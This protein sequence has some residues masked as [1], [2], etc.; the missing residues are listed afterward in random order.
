M[1]TNQVYP[2]STDAIQIVAVNEKRETLTIKNF[3]SLD[4]KTGTLCRI[5]N[6]KNVTKGEGYILD[7]N[8]VIHL[9]KAD[10]D[11][12]DR[13]WYARMVSGTGSL[14]IIEQFAE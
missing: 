10:G 14:C 12:P 3:S 7:D 4:S 6:S 11:K 13:E 1:P 8:E 5:S 9:I 2:T